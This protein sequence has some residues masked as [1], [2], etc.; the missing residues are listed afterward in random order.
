[1]FVIGLGH[2]ARH[3]KDYVAKYMVQHAAKKG[4]Y[5]KTFSLADALKAHCRVTY[6][7]R[8]KDPY[9]L[10][11]VGTEVVRR[12][13]PNLWVD[14]CMATIAE[15]A[16]DV[17]LIPDMRFENEVQAVLAANGFVVK[18]SRTN[19]D[20]SAWVSTDR[21]PN[22][23][24]EIALDAYTAW[25]GTITVPSGQ[26]DRLKMEAEFVFDGLYEHYLRHRQGAAS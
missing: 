16:P 5:A 10:Q 18:V 3:G 7:M 17:A 8:E 22:H 19:P 4:L 13:Q 15:Q 1:M 11:I 25:D 24:S 20:G 23:P 9:L 26:I 14:I 12:I 21:N 2:K 6:G